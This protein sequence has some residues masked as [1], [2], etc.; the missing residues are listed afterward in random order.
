[1]SFMYILC[2][3]VWAELN[4]N[5]G[6]VF[7][8]FLLW[9]TGHLSSPSRSHVGHFYSHL[10]WP[11]G[12]LWAEPSISGHSILWQ[13]VDLNRMSHCLVLC[14]VYP[15]LTSKTHS[16]EYLSWG[17]RDGLKV[18]YNYCCGRARLTHFLG[19]YDPC[20]REKRVSFFCTAQGA[21]IYIECVMAVLSLEVGTLWPCSSS[22]WGL[23]STRNCKKHQDS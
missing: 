15:H 23:K 7:R 20:L 5:A 17:G 14:S 1:M 3:F 4:K 22:V 11:G 18:G 6:K 19:C 16:S 21:A 12:V 13:R 2:I 10:W 8:T 9:G